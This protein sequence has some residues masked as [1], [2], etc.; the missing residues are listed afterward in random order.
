[1]KIYEFISKILKG[2]NIFLILI[3]LFGLLY[4]IPLFRN[5]IPETHDAQSLIVK[6]A[7]MQNSLSDFQIP[8]RWAG[9]LN[10]NFGAPILNFYYPLGGYFGNIL[11]FFGFGLEFGYKLLL[12][13][14]FIFSGISFFYLGSFF[15]RK[16]AAF[17]AAV[18]YML[19]PYH[20]LDLFVRGHL[21]ELV[22]LSLAP[23]VLY[24]IVK[25]SKDKNITYI[26]LGSFAYALL[27]ISHNI[28]ALLFS[29]VFVLYTVFFNTNVKKLLKS[30]LIFIVG[31]GLS[32]YFW[33]P[34]LYEGKYINSKLFLSGFYREHF[35]N[36]SNIIYSPWGF[37]PNI[38]EPGGLSPQIGIIVIVLCTVSLLNLKNKK[39]RKNI[40]FWVLVLSL[41][42][43]F[44]NQI[45]DVLWSRIHLLEQFQFPW[46]FIAI[47]SFAATLLSAYALNKFS[48]NWM[49]Y[50]I[51]AI[52]LIVSFSY[53]RVKG[54][55][56]NPDSFYFNYP[57]TSAF[58]GESTTIWSE[59]DASTYPKQAI[60]IIAGQGTVESYDR[61]S[62][63]H[64]YKI[65]AQ[66]DVGIREN[67]N[68][69]PGWKAYVDGKEVEIQFQDGNHRGIITF[70][71]PKGEHNVEI[72]FIE[73]TV[74]LIADLISLT[75]LTF[76]II[77][78]IF[79][80]KFA[81]LISAL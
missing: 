60:E 62:N 18:I 33:L 41:S 80:K 34:A 47:A 50:M 2:K 81:K 30:M 76:L 29:V 21:G 70:Q 53:M 6:T 75:F 79:R 68:Y 10:Y 40:V 45:S 57:G 69:Y 77:I 1:M 25:Y 73:T 59:G 8:P 3:V 22:A 38:N 9:D 74:R 5:E 17:G 36:F 14:A 32:A 55:E 24:F 28:L 56:K 11:Y 51:V 71:V 66:S 12:G 42:I 16:E 39:E 13:L 54:Y 63:L 35:I 78:S 44:T 27:I 26:I 23:L 58:H 20:F 65:I 72:K 64:R 48:K 43:F 61:K 31:L 46:R 19:A 15:F 37:G 7:A 67:T 4:L 49:I 52:A